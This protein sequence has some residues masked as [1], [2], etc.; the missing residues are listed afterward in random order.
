MTHAEWVTVG[1][2]ILGGLIGLA[3][4]LLVH[5]WRCWRWD[6]QHRPERRWHF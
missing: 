6:K 1:W 3:I 5:M 4:I 2:T